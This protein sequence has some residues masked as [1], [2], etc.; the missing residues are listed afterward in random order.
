ML[1]EN[2]GKYLQNSE[3]FIVWDEEKI[4]KSETG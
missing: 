1:F 3:S 4:V 2:V